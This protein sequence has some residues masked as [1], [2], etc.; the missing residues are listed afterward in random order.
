MALRLS[1]GAGAVL[2]GAAAVAGCSKPTTTATSSAGEAAA[3]TSGYVTE[4]PSSDKDADVTG[5]EVTHKFTGNI[6]DA[7][8][9][10]VLFLTHNCVGC[11]GGLAGGAMGPSLRDTVWKFGGS[12][13]AL[14][15]SIHD[16][17]PD[18]MPAWGK[19]TSVVGEQ[20]DTL[21]DQQI[22]QLITYI[23]SM[24]TSD[25]P[26]FFFWNEQPGQSGSTSATS[27]GTGSS[28]QKSG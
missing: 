1:I 27:T 4:S 14:F 21:S 17:R 12:D 20:H 2:F 3:I 10:R 15:A 28:G 9:G 22:Q 7:N 26:T 13:Q 8:A 25:E 24:R 5:I 18:G 19:T 11:H 6:A 16:G 23:H